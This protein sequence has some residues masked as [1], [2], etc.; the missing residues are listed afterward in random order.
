MSLIKIHNLTFAYPGSYD[1]VFENASFVMDTDWKLGLIGR[2]GK[3]KTTLMRLLMG[4]YKYNGTITSTV[5]F[6]YFPYEIEHPDY[7]TCDVLQEACPNVQSWQI[8]KEFSKLALTEENYY[9]PFNQ[10]SNGQQNK[11]LIAALF[12]GDNNF[13]LIDEPTNHLDMDTR[14][15]VAKYLNTKHG[16]ILVSHDRNFLDSC[17]DHIVSINKASIDICKGNFSSWFEDFSSAQTGKVKK[18]ER[19]NKEIKRLEKSAM[20]KAE[21]SNKKEA[22]VKGA[23]YFKGYVSHRAAKMMKRSKNVERN[24]QRKIQDR[25]GLLDDVEEIEDLKIA[26]VSFRANSLITLNNVIPSYNN[27]SVCSELSFEIK[28]GDR[29][30]LNGSNGCGKSTILKIITEQNINYDGLVTISSGLKISYLPQ[31]VKK[32]NGSLDDYIY[33]A[34][35]EISL[36]KALLRKLGFS[37]DQ[38]FKDISDYSLG[39]QR[40]VLIAKSLLEPANIYIWDEPLNYLDIYCRQQIENLIIRYQPTMI[41]VEHDKAFVDKVATESIIIN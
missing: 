40:K 3:G 30:A 12:A 25:Q 34:G 18:N 35:I 38:F 39:Q 15:Q 20:Q 28:K 23:G 27:K 8:L 26:Y 17:V 7:L 9:Q 37:R 13:L 10:L 31:Q 33:D 11:A 2:N 32:F 29:L 24:Q 4:Q 5:N 1:N 6:S 36:F 21:W 19:L 16:Y 14:E 41:F 22:S